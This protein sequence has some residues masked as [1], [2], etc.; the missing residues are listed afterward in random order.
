MHSKYVR[1]SIPNFIKNSVPPTISY[2]Y[3]KTIAGKIFNFKQCVKNIDFEVGT[4]GISCDCHTSHFRYE[5]VGHVI[6]GNLG[7]IEK[8]IGN[9]ENY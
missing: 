4:T 1:K 6:T 8:L 9:L 7:I 2:S 3:T 5:P